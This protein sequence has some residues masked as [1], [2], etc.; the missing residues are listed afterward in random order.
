MANKDAPRGLTPVQVQSGPFTGKEK[1]YKKEASTIIGVGDCV[2]LTGSS[3]A[4][5]GIALVDRAAAASGTITG[6][7]TRID[8]IRTSLGQKHLNASDTGYIFVAD[9]PNQLFEIQED[10]VGNNLLVTDVGEGVDLVVGDANTTTGRSIME[11]DSSTSAG[12]TGN[13][14]QLRLMGLKQSSDNALGAN[15][16]WIVLINEHTYKAAQTMI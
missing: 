6:V 16:T 2:V 13:A 11:I 15:A 8:P 5:T 1:M 7:V 3:E 4:V 12:E 9:D 10:S 14:D